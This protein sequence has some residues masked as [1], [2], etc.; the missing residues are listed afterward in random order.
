MTNG[1]IVVLG[2]VVPIVFVLALFIGPR[3]EKKWM[4]R[5]LLVAG[6]LLLVIGLAYVVIKR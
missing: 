3:E 4:R 5:G 6:F 1:M 2:I